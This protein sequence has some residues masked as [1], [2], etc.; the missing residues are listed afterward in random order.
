MRR[1]SGS[2][3]ARSCMPAFTAASTVAAFLL[4]LAPLAARAGATDA[5]PSCG[6]KE[7]TELLNR[8]MG[9]QAELETEEAL[10]AYEKCLK[11][12]PECVACRYEIG[13]SYWKLGRW[14]D[15]IKTWEGVQ[16]LDPNHALVA[17]YLP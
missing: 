12:E 7:A 6:A 4:L 1:S 3:G 16:K 15:V 17:Q 2:N 5:P 10:A 11:T 13:W 8:G 9:L 14:E